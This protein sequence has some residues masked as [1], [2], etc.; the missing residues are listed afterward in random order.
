MKTIWKFQI[1]IKD[2]FIL[3]MPKDSKIIAVNPQKGLPFIWAMV[4]DSQKRE[5]REFL[6]IGT[7][8]DIGRMD[9]L[10]KFSYRGTFFI[11]D[12]LLVFHLFEKRNSF[13][14]ELMRD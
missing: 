14:G 6:L 3:M 2:E 5:I 13:F 7:G 8:Y 12:G 11:N 4:D 10:Y 9:N 1:E